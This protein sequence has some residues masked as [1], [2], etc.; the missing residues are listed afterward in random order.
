M[1]QDTL[2][3]LIAFLIVLLFVEEMLFYYPFV[4]VYFIIGDYNQ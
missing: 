4:P 3:D 2:P 1:K